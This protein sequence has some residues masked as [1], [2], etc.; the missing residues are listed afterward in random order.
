M[1]TKRKAPMKNVKDIDVKDIDVKDIDVKAIVKVLISEM[2]DSDLT[3]VCE[4]VTDLEQTRRHGKLILNREAYSIDPKSYWINNYKIIDPIS[5]CINNY[6][7]ID[8]KSYW[9]NNYKIIPIWS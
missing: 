4:T 2:S 1:P 6:K 9:I 7:I 8:P 5:Y 3:D